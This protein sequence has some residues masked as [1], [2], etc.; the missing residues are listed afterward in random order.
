MVDNIDN[1]ISLDYQKF[2]RGPLSFNFKKKVIN[3]ILGTIITIV[4]QLKDIF[5]YTRAMGNTA[6]NI[7]L[8]E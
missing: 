6:G 3:L 8:F 4:S 5:K 2:Y 7:R 1:F